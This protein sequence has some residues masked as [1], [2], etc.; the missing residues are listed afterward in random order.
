[1]YFLTLALKTPLFRRSHPYH[2]LTNVKLPDRKAHP[3]V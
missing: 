1:V 3:L 2:A